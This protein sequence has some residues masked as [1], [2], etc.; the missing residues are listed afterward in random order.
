MPSSASVV[1]CFT[2]E[3][4]LGAEDVMFTFKKIDAGFRVETDF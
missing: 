2:K 1:F 4:Q 3:M